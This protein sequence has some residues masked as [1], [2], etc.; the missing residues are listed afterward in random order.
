MPPVAAFHV[1]QR[2]C[3]LKQKTEGATG[4]LSASAGLD[5]LS[6]DE[7]PIAN[8]LNI[9]M[10]RVICT[11]LTFS[12]CQRM[13]LLTDDL[14]RKMLS[15]SIDR[16][17]TRYRF[18]LVAFVIMPEHAHLL[19]DPL[20]Q[21]PKLDR[22]LGAIKRPFSF[23][24]KVLLQAADS[25]VLQKLTIRE[26]PGRMVFRFWQEGPGYDRNLSSKKAVLAAIDYI[27]SNPVR[28]GLVDRA[29]QWKWS[30]SRWY[31]MDRARLDPDLPKVHGLRNGSFIE[32]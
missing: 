1:F 12:C 10:S 26:R 11:E 3:G 15:N 4:R 22:L 7:Q 19:V 25:P 21:Q 17:M 18:R 2:S 24:I 5:S 8:A 13:Q 29:R 16:A 32:S 28:R 6:Q 31:E 9:I 23:R 27:H 20:E 14:W 30:S